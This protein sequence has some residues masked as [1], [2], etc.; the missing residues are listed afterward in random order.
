[1]G[2]PLLSHSGLAACAQADEASADA[3]LTAQALDHLADALA[4]LNNLYSLE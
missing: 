2:E 3:L 1:M 4:S